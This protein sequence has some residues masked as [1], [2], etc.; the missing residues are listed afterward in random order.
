MVVVSDAES[1]REFT[2][3]AGQATPDRPVAFEKE[4]VFFLAK[5]MLD[6]IMEFTATVDGPAVCKEKLKSFVRDSKDIPQ[7]EYD[8]EGDGAVRKVADQA[9]ALVDS[10]Y[11]SLNA[12]AK[13]GINLSSVFNVVH[14]ANMDK[15]DPVTNEFLKRA[16]GKIIKP[17]GWQPPNIDK[18]ILRQQTEGSF[19]SQL[20]TETHIP[21]SDA[22]MVR[23]FTAGAGQPTPCQPVAFTREEVFFLAKMM[24]D[25]IMEFTATVAG[26]EE[27]K[28]TL[29]QFIDK[30]KDIEQEVYE[31]NDA[32]QVKKIGDQADALVDSYY[33]SLNAAARQGINLSALFEIVHQANMNKRCPVTKKFLRRDD[34]KI[35]KPKGWMPPNIEGEIQRQMDETSFPSVQVLEKKFE[36]QCNLV[37][38]GQ[39][40]QAKN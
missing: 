34:G 1:V 40:L 22:E 17:A 9:D 28:S 20:P 14:Q 35:I 24:L 30:S 13:K 38:E 33:Y 2:K 11:Y 19:P 10:Y 21:N 32:G 3:G 36:H 23:E 39:V 5:M 7:E 25:E 31:D 16:D 29:C 15:R 37:R 18:E 8:M 12:A 6:E 26:P 27:S 4:D